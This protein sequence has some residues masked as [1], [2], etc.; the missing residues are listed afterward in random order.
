MHKI[1]DMHGAYWATANAS[2][3]DNNIIYN[4]MKTVSEFSCCRIITK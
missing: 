2:T 3:D 4:L 1:V